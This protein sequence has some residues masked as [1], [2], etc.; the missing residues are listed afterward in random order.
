GRQALDEGVDHLDARTAAGLLQLHHVRKRLC[1][2]RSK[3]IPVALLLF[4]SAQMSVFAAVPAAVVVLHV[5]EQQR[6]VLGFDRDLTAHG[7]A[8][9][10]AP[11][12]AC[13]AARS[14]A[15]MRPAHSLCPPSSAT[16]SWRISISTCGRPRASPCCG[17]L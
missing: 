17:M 2:Q 12:K 5:D 14:A 16:R 9:R 10:Y 7:M 1:A 4:G 8:H 11:K 15:P 6:A 13:S 3:E